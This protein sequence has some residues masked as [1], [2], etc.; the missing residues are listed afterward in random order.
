MAE[1]PDRK[2]AGEVCVLAREIALA[3]FWVHEDLFEDRRDVNGLKLPFHVTTTAGGR[4]VDELILD[5][6]LVNPE[7]GKDDFKR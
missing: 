1:S 7:I 2:A 6:I 3:D 5:Q 4:I